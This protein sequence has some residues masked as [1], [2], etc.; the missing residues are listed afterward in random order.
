MQRC[1][2]EATSGDQ[3]GMYVAPGMPRHAYYL[4]HLRARKGGK[5]DAWATRSFNEVALFN[6]ITTL[7]FHLDEVMNC[8][9]GLGLGT[10]DSSSGLYECL[11]SKN[12][13]YEGTHG[14]QCREWTERM[15]GR[16]R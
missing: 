1:S 6:L 9:W 8:N 13:M 14:S 16:P 7:S 5:E 3:I 2:A 10:R 12:R 11:R 4:Q 15:K